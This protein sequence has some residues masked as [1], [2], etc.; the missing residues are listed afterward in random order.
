MTLID[1]DLFWSRFRFLSLSRFLICPGIGKGI[2]YTACLVFA[3]GKGIGKTIADDHRRR[4]CERIPGSRVTSSFSGLCKIYGK[5]SGYEKLR[6]RSESKIATNH[7][8]YAS[9][10]FP[11]VPSNTSSSMSDMNN[12]LTTASVRVFRSRRLTGP[13]VTDTVSCSLVG[14]EGRDG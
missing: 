4:G 1:L 6:F 13:S 10:G 11:H 7:F 9:R 3:L 8:R 5:I 14:P 12:C 2:A